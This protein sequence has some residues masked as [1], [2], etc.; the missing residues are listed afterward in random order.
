VIDVIVNASR[1][2]YVA[3]YRNKM[4]QLPTPECETWR[5]VCRDPET[6]GLQIVACVSFCSDG[7]TRTMR[8]P[9]RSVKR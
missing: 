9:I 6:R 3:S 8:A 2:I 4:L 1:W 7:K 5:F